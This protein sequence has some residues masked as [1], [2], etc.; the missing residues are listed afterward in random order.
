MNKRLLSTIA[1]A[2]FV[3]WTGYNV[4]VSQKSK[5]LSDLLLDNIEA[6]ADSGESSESNCWWFGDWYACIPTGGGLGCPCGSHE[7]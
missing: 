6:L 3:I 4:Y 2:T 7:W 1:V 5:S